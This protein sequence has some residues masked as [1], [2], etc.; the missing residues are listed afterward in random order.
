M[1][2][3]TTCIVYTTCPDRAAADEL[4]AALIERR[5]A[6]CVSIGAPVISTY[7]WKGR[8][9]T[10]DEVPLTIKTMTDRLEKLENAFAE[11]HPYEVPEMLAVPATWGHG[12]YLEWMKEN[13][14][15]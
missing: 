11:L 5:L 10:D 15:D 12:P 9:E 3:A 6:A 14:D 4:A 1:N 2:D 7:P 13:L 8:V